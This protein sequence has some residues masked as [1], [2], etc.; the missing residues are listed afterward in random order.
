MSTTWYWIAWQKLEQISTRCPVITV[1][2][3]LNLH[4]EQDDLNSYQ[5]VGLPVC[6]F[7]NSLL[8]SPPSH[9]VIA[10]SLEP[11]TLFLLRDRRTV[12]ALKDGPAMQFI[13]RAPR[14]LAALRTASSAPCKQTSLYWMIATLPIT[15]A[16]DARPKQLA[17]GPVFPTAARKYRYRDGREALLRVLSP[18]PCRHEPA[19]DDLVMLETLS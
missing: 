12:P 10:L 1:K 4:L 17:Q 15:P 14:G 7:Y 19:L 3:T 16:L 8:F 11:S 9:P 13:G 6:I 5:A 18:P 2:Q